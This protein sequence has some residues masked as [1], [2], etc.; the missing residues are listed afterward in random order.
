MSRIDE[1]LDKGTATPD[2]IAYLLDV[3]LLARDIAEPLRFAVRENLPDDVSVQA[4]V[5]LDA[6]MGQERVTIDVDAE[7]APLQLGD[8]IRLLHAIYDDFPEVKIPDYD[9]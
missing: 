7:E 1:I 8:L 5:Q 4:Y 6:A 3:I 2:D 9:A